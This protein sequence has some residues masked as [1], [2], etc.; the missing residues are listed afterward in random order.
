MKSDNYIDYQLNNLANDIDSKLSRKLIVTG[1]KKS[2]KS[3]LLRYYTKKFNN[4]SRC[5]IYVDY[6]DFNYKADLSNKEYQLYYELVFIK[7]MLESVN[8]YNNNIKSDFKVFESYITNEYCKFCDFLM[9]RYCANDDVQFEQGILVKKM[10]DIFY[11]LGISNIS[12]VIDHFDFVG[13]SS[14]RF[15]KFMECYFDSFN[16]VIITTNENMSEEKINNL[17]NKKIDIY[18]VDNGHDIKYVK[19][20][21]QAYLASIEHDVVYD[22]DYIVRLHNIYK[23]LKDN[24]FYEELIDRCNGNIDMMQQVIRY[25]IIG[26]SLENSIDSTVRLQNEI[27]GLTYKR[28]LHL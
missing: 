16:K 12:L 17:K 9:T 7:K 20:V 11:I 6:K 8:I 22:V 21:L 18:R 13:K 27:D 2:G 19:T 1:E 10:K 15:Q 25:Y 14:E 4:N 24:S 23:L 26:D 3:E 5:V 28:I